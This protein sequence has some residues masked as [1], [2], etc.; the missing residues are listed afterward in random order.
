MDGFVGALL[1]SEKLKEHLGVWWKEMDS[2]ANL[3]FSWSVTMCEL[4]CICFYL[5]SALKKYSFLKQAWTDLRNQ[6]NIG[7]KKTKH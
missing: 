4:Y 5:T 1:C 2:Y 7:P 6:V 3:E